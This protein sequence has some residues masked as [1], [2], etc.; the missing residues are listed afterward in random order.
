MESTIHDDVASA[1]CQAA[2]YLLRFISSH[3]HATLAF[4]TTVAVIGSSHFSVF[5]L[6][7]V[8]VFGKRY[9]MDQALFLFRGGWQSSQGRLSV[10]NW[11]AMFVGM[12]EYR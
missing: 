9:M 12:V 6:S 10:L 7:F 1:C 11:L 4:S 3:A 5:P 8:I 2:L